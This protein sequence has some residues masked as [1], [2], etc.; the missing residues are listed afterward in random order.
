MNQRGKRESQP[1]TN[2]DLWPI[3]VVNIPPIHVRTGHEV[4]PCGW[5]G[6]ADLKGE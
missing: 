1:L 3:D 6:H 5:K 4:G 2:V